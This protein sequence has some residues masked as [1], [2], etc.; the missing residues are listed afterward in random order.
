MILAAGSGTRLWPITR[1]RPKCLVEIDG[2]PTMQHAIE[3]LRDA[4]VFRIIVN[5]CHLRDQIMD[6]FG[7]G[8][9]FGVDISYSIEEEPLGTAGG[10][11]QAA[12]FFN[13]LPFIVWYG[14]NI[15]NCRLDLM[16]GL[17][18]YKSAMLTMALF[19]RA[20]VSQSGVAVSDDVRPD[21]G[22]LR[23]KSRNKRKGRVTGLTRASIWFNRKS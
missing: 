19:Q 7:D 9:R 1:Q 2:K 20:D 12:W 15:A 4:G 18:R 8:R 10:V 21:P 14:D 5:V 6:Y 16:W 3:R 23:G 17:H 22:Q 13:D 11:R